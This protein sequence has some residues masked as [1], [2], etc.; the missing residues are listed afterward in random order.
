M[1]FPELIGQDGPRGV[2]ERILVSGRIPHAIL[3]HGPEGIGKGA[4]AAAFSA[5]LLCERP[6]GGAACGACPAC[7]KAG[8]GN[9]PDLMVVTRLPKAKK[10]DTTT[11]DED[12][13]SAEDAASASGKGDLKRQITIDQIRDLNEHATYAPREGARRVFVVDPADAM[14]AAS[15]NALLKTLEEPPGRAV[16]LLVASRPHLLLPTI[17]SRC[18]QIGF[19]AMHPASLAAALEKRGMPR[20]EARSRA[21]LSE[22]RPGRALTLDLAARR[23]HRDEALARLVAL[24]TDPGAAAHLPAWAKAMTSEET[25]LD[26]ELDLAAV[27]LRDAARAAAGDAAIVNAD[28]APGIAKLGEALGARRAAELLEYVDRLR[29]DLRLNL[30]RALVAESFLA[31]VAGAEVVRTF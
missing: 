13:D 26:D 8:H 28:A 3:F 12:E 20:D 11:N 7:R 14:N 10:G 2:L 29:H 1:I 18:F 6:N 22:G 19:G 4:I 25:D 15:Q 30:N 23:A 5:S 31:S 27:L 16:L 21:A 24:A 17:R 9:H